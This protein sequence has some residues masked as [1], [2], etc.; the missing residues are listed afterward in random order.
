MVHY[1]TDYVFDGSGSGPG[2]KR[3]TRPAVR[4]MATKLE[5][6]QLIQQSGCQHLILRTSWVYAARG[7]NFAKPCCAWQER[8]RLTVID[9]QW[10]RLPAPSCW[11]TS[12]PTPCASC[13]APRRRRPVP[14]R[15]RGRNH[16]AFLCKIRSRARQSSATSY[17]NKATEVARC[18][19]APSRRRR[20][21][22]TTSR[23][24]TPA[25]CKPPSA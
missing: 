9:D 7:G 17:Q 18:P 11:P 15:G 1:S 21:A 19:P 16:L 10:V 3:R 22:R 14:L 20:G 25:S 2:S 13:R 5:G 8:E 12:P 4:A 23:L 24:N 6:E